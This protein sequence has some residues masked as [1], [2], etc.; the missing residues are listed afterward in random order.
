MRL[1]SIECSFV[2]PLEGKQNE[3]FCNDIRAWSRVAPHLFIWDYVTNFSN[4]IL[5]HPN[6]RVLAPNIRFFVDNHVI[7]LFEQGDSGC[8]VG[9]FVRLRAWLLAH[10]MWDP[11]RDPQLLIRELPKATMGRPGRTCWPT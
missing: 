2:Q 3:T 5:P 4:Y 8:S 6:M 7:G 10:L 9:D 11:R 1:C